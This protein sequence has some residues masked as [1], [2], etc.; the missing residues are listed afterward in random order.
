[1]LVDGVRQAS[2]HIQQVDAEKD[3]RGQTK[4]PPTHSWRTDRSSKTDE[5]RCSAHVGPVADDTH[6]VSVFW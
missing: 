4:P 3:E 1:M 5:L 2:A 6:I